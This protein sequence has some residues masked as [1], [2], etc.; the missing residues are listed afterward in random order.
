MGKKQKHIIFIVSI[1]ASSFLIFAGGIFYFLQNSYSFEIF[2]EEI[3][4]L[5][6]YPEHALTGKRCENYNQRPYAV[7]LAADTITRPLSGISKADVVIE[8]QVVKSSITRIMSL[9]AC[10]E[11]QEIGSIRSSRHDFIPLAASFDAIYAHWGGSYLA[12]DSLNKG[13]IDNID[14]LINPFNVFF[15]KDG[16][17]AP[18]D[19]FTSFEKLKNTAERLEYRQENIFEGY[20]RT[21]LDQAQLREVDIPTS[22]SIEYP[23]PYNVTYIY[24]KKTNSYLRWRG[25]KPEIDMLNDQQVEVKILVV[26]F[27][28]SRQLD[29]DYNDVDVTGTGDALVFQ[30]GNMRRAKWEKA[31]QPLS[32][33]LKFLDDTGE[34]ILFVKGN[35][36]IHI[37][38]IGTEVRWGEEIL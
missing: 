37:L 3:E 2:P 18:H 30:N 38:D 14:A 33:K 25:N 4:E 16:I 11:P 9:F 10:E 12:L 36:W 1:I 6:L 17:L 20:P 31:E 26:M 35:M 27:T 34:E 32:S 13:I 28:N 22:I 7:M 29:I 8:M 24:R 15:R 5:V 21:E 19:G 23:F